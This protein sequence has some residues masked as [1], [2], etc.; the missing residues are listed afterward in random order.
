MARFE[1]GLGADTIVENSHEVFVDGHGVARSGVNIAGSPELIEQYRQGY[2]CLVCHH[3][4]TEAFPEVC[5]AA[6][7]S[8]GGTWRCG[9]RI[10]DEQVRR[11]E[12]E[13][14]GEHRYGPSPLDGHE[15]QWERDDW[16]PKTGIWVPQGFDA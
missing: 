5:E 1:R 3:V 7:R 11:L 12:L 9:F 4:Q 16:T 2:R 8:P 15:E 6:D 10:R 14:Q 13:H